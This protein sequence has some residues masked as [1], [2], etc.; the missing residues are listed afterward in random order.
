MKNAR[1]KN[2]RLTRSSDG[3][4]K[5]RTMI[6]WYMIYLC[7]MSCLKTKVSILVLPNMKKS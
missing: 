7:P 4:T 5:L 6:D 3:G 2:Q 1:K